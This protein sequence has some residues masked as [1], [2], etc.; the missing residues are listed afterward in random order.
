MM[1]GSLIPS[2]IDEYFSQVSITKMLVKMMIMLFR[3]KAEPLTP[4]GRWG[5]HWEKRLIHQ[6]YYD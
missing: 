3:I 6:K 2:K 5:H 4:L 1:T